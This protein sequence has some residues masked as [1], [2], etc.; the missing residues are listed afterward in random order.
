MAF[1]VGGEDSSDL[2]HQQ[3][4]HL[5]WDWERLFPTVICDFLGY[6]QIFGLPTWRHLGANAAAGDTESRALQIGLEFRDMAKS[7]QM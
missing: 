5:L 1:H 4:A 3:T 6:L 7:C 2:H